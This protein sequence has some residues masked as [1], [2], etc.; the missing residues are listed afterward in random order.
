MTATER[1]SNH[2]LPNIAR[3]PDYPD[4]HSNRFL[5]TLRL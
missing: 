4:I 5:L 1:L 2:A 3:G